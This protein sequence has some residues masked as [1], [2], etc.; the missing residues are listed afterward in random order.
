[1]ESKIEAVGYFSKIYEYDKIARLKIADGL[2]ITPGT[3]VKLYVEANNKSV[4]MNYT[5]NNGEEYYGCTLTKDLLGDIYMPKGA[6]IRVEYSVDIL[7]MPNLEQDDTRYS[8]ILSVD[9]RSATITIID[10]KFKRFDDKE[11]P[12]LF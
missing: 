8:N 6:K 11:Y 12:Y 9:D 3:E 5:N 1:M 2:R 10:E 4:L 7:Q